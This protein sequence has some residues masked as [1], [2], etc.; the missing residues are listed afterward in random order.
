V[1][2]SEHLSLPDADQVRA[3]VIA[4]RIAGH[5]ADIA[6]GLPGASERDR[7]FS[8]L[9]DRRDWKSQL[10]KALDPAA[11]KRIREQ[12]MSTNRDVCSMCGPFCPIAL[13]DRLCEM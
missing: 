12:G 1:T 5:A 10:E 3:G 8:E 7:E 13:Q 9:R 6:R 11:A 4:A 2:P